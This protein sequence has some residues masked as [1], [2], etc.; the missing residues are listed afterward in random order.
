MRALQVL[1]TL[2]PF[3]W[4]IGGL[5]FAN[6]VRPFVLGLPFLAFWVLM[7]IPIGFLCLL[8]I[9]KLEHRATRR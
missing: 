1:L 4:T 8:A 6:R 3:A 2:I 9:W 7:G 5:P